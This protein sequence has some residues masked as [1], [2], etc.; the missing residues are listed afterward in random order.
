MDVNTYIGFEEHELV[1]KQKQIDSDG[2]KFG[3][4][5]YDKWAPKVSDPSPSITKSG[6]RAESKASNTI[7]L[8]AMKHRVFVSGIKASIGQAEVENK[9]R[10]DLIGKE[11]HTLIEKVTVAK[12]G[13]YVLHFLHTKDIPAF[14]KKYSGNDFLGGKVRPSQG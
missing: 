11:D 14:I 13:T 8:N 5:I 1:L 2:N 4:I 3:W 9:L 10:S 7:D 6:H 12:K